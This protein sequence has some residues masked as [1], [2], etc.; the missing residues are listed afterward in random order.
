MSRPK[1]VVLA[2][3][4]GWGVAPD[5]EGN[6]LTRAELPNYRRFVRDYPAMTLYASS[7]EVGLSFGEMGNSEVGHLNIGAGRVYYQTL[8]RIDKSITDESFFSNQAFLNAMDHAKKKDGALHLIGIVSPGNVHGSEA[9]CYALLDLAKRQKVKKVYIHVI[10][11]GRDT[12]YNSGIDFVRRLVEKTKEYGIGTIASISGRFYAMDRDNR[13]ER[14]EKAYRAMA[15]GVAESYAT[16]PVAAVQASYDK[17][18]YDEEFV[19][20]VMGSANKPVGRM[21]GND[22][23]ICFNFRPDR[24]RELTEAFVLPAFPK[25]DRTYIRGLFFVTMTEYEKEIPVLV[26]YPPVVVHQC[27]AEVLSNAGLKQFH[28]AETEKYAHITFFLNGTIED[29]FPNE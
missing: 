22:A 2:I 12:I 25:F 10:I 19:P 6:A 11:D 26:A 15:E 13:W 27:L 7:N 28:I 21:T 1:P 14:V 20:V 24:A 4:D 8:P 9:H 29:P 5:A 18:V 3:C 17:G 16:D 23:A